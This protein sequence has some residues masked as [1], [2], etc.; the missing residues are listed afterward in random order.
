MPSPKTQRRH[1]RRHVDNVPPRTVARSSLAKAR[2]AIEVAPDTPET[3]AAVTAALGALDRAVAKGVMHR[4]AAA[5]H[6]SNLTIRLTKA[7]GGAAS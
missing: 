1:A 3:L 2:A 7:T 6:K 5:R 4:N